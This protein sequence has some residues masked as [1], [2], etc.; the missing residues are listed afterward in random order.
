MCTALTTCAF[1]L[2]GLVITGT[3]RLNLRSRRGQRGVARTIHDPRC[4][5]LATVGRLD[6]AVLSLRGARCLKKSLVL[7]RVFARVGR[8]AQRPALVRGAVFCFLATVAKKMAE[9]AARACRF[10]SDYGTD[11]FTMA[12]ANSR[13]LDRIRCCGWCQ[14]FSRLA[15]QVRP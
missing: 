7:V 11:S 4:T 1:N 3:S 13:G 14:F 10:H 9:C 15:I 5:R 12:S 2:V 6:P 8:N